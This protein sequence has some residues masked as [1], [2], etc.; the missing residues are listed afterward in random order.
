MK[1]SDDE[2]RK[3]KNRERQQAWRAKNRPKVNASRRAA[4]ASTN[5]WERRRTYYFQKKYGITEEERDQLLAS[6][7][8][9]CA[10]CKTDDP[11][12]KLGWVIDHCHTSGRVRGVLCHR[13][14][15]M[16]GMSCDSSSTLANAIKYLN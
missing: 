12:S 1:L 6:Q 3:R 13:C 2:E 5:E 16:L 10:I 9:V 15:V 11:K 8:G 7:G 4:Y 14:N